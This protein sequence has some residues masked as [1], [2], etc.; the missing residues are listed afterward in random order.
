MR[1]IKIMAHLVAGYPGRSQCLEAARALKDSG[2]EILELQ[3]PFSDP[4]AD[5]PVITSASE[6]AL[7]AGFKVQEIFDYIS[8]AKNLGFEEVHVMTYANIVYSWGIRKYLE[9]MRQSGVTG[10]IVPDFPLEDDDGFY[11]ASGE[12]GIDALPVAVPN[13]TEHR[14]S[15][16]RR[17]S[18][19]RVYAA[20]RQGVTG[21]DTQITGKSLE[22]LKSLQVEKV[23][24]GFGINTAAH[25]ASLQ[26][27]AYAAVIG[28]HIT[29]AFSSGED[30]YASIRS[31]IDQ[32]IFP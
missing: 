24:A 9:D 28:S 13:M 5:G 1:Q 12:I 19:G 6:K 21:Q 4:T 10:V 7:Q 29:R 15:L 22:F 16:L 11:Q 8:A 26:G 20:L 23:Y 25:V 27:Y 17:V 30:T 2:V 14:I 3:I 31:A 18:P 32:C